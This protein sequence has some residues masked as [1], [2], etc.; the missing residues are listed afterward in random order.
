MSD[1]VIITQ[2]SKNKIMV[3]RAIQPDT[4]ALLIGSIVLNAMLVSHAN[5]YEEALEIISN[6]EK[7][8]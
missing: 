8:K 2:P 5:S 7:S 6:L 3:V 4:G 1:L